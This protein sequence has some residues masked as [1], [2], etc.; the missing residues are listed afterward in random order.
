MLLFLSACGT[1]DITSSSQGI[2]EGGILYSFS[3]IIIWLSNLFG[4]NY[5]VG[6]ILFVLIIRILLLPATHL[7]TKSMRQM[8]M[9]NPKV[10]ILK[11]K[12]ASKDRQTQEKLKEATTRLYEEE[13]IN[14]LYGL[15]PLVLQMPILLALYQAIS[16][17]PELRS[18]V[19]LWTNLGK[20]DPYFILPIL[21]ALLTWW[22]SKLTSM[23]GQ[24]Q[25]AALLTY[26]MPFF[27]FFVSIPLP[28][29]LSL[30]FVVTNGFSVIQTLLLNNPYKIIQEEKEK[31]AIERAEQQNRKKAL[32]KAQKLGRNVRK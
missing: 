10:E 15:L 23:S 28:S 24:Q 9:L 14:P 22:N 26:I 31:E 19:F 16:R 7:Q 2:W 27:I 18:G 12:Y 6:I 1:G 21:A 13:G 3:K 29:A 11:Q 32:R 25:G 17:T 4:G 8:Q 20:A 30:Y 5:G